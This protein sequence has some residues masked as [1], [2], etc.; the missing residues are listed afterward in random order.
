LVSAI[1]LTATWESRALC[2]DVDAGCF[3]PPLREESEAER[4]SRELAAKRVCAVCPVQPQCLDYALRMSEPFGIWGGLNE[5]E[6]R[7]LTR[8]RPS[9]RSSD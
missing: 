4:R 2:R 7:A 5:V 3:I 1:A 8:A 6:R 9:E